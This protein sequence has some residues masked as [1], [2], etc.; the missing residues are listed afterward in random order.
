[1]S[2]SLKSDVVGVGYLGRFHAQKHKAL[3]TLKFGCDAS[4]TRAQE[5][6]K[7]MGCEAVSDPKALIGKVQAVTIAVDTRSHYELCNLFL[8]NGIH[9][10]VEKPICTTVEEAEKIVSLAE[11]K[12]LKLAVGHVERFNPAFVVGSKL[13]QKP[14]YVQLQRLAPFK[15]RSLAVDVVLDLMIHDLDLATSIVRSPVRH[16]RAKGAK[17]ITDFNDACDAWIEYENG[18]EAFISCSRVDQKTVRALNVFDQKG[19]VQIDL[20]TQSVSRL[21]QAAGPS[22]SPLESRSVAV[23]KWDA[24]QRETEKFF[25]AIE[26]DQEVLVTGKQGLEALRSAE[27]IL[28][29]CR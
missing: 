14:H 7:E 11:Q 15:P 19:I 21:T 18:A 12:K 25:E 8:S 3:G 20:G 9:V 26:K 1:M 17:V 2:F 4:S 23:E 24:M 13:V 28:E 29:L 5:I 27:K 10:F 6:A 22:I 16:I